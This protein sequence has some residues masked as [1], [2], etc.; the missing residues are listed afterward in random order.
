MG[1]V[2]IDVDRLNEARVAARSMENAIRASYDQCEEL[3]SYV[4]SAK[5]SGKSRDSFLSYLEII[6]QYH[7]DLKE[8]AVLQTK[9]LRN[10]S[11]YIND[12]SKD[13]AVKEVRNL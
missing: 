7:K 9:A 13:S 10:L 8:A 3:L 12:F 5:W 6:A 11:D 1:D 4:Q 2:K